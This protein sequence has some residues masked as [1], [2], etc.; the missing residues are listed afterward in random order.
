[1][2][3]CLCPRC[4]GNSKYNYLVDKMYYRDENQ[5]HKNDFMS[6]D[7]NQDGFV[8]AAEVKSQFPT[9]G[10]EDLSAFF[11]SA[12]KD[13]DGLI[14]LNEYLKASLA[15]ENGSLDLNDYKVF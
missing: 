8:D 3:A 12:D 2:Y 4:L 13:E 15:H 9:I 10:P 14:S 6:F 1:M 5:E 7:V 11:I